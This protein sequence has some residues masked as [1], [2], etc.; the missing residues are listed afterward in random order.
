MSNQKR[1]YMIAGEA[2]GEQIGADVMRAIQ[3][4]FPD[5]EIAGIGGESMLEAGMESLFPMQDISLMGFAEIIPHLFSLLQR[6]RQ[7]VGDIMARQPDILITIDSPGFNNRVIK[8][9]K[10]RGFK[11]P[12]IHIVAP[13]VWAYKPKRAERAAKLYDHLLTILPFEAPYFEKHGLNTTF[14]GHPYAWKWLERPDGDSFKYE[15][16]IDYN[17]MLIGLMPGSRASEI[18]HHLPIFKEAIRQLIPVIDDFAVVIPTRN[19]LVKLIEQ[20]TKDWPTKLYVVV[21]DEKKFN[22]IAACRTA[23]AKSG[24]VSLEMAFAGVPAITA[25]KANPISAWLVRQMI[26]IQYVNLI[27]II[28]NRAVVPEY[29]QEDCNADLLAEAVGMVTTDEEKRAE[30]KADYNAVKKSLLL[31]KE[32]SPSEYAVDVIANYL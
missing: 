1:I 12:I 3:D 9:L 23:L 10:K 31:S 5:A 4:R 29:L 13:T 24:T 16:K 26:S 11:Q 14:I 30:M 7:T 32:K 27:N 19:H 18:H 28:A 2:S 15:E 25:Y 6:I 17:T 20:Y 21:G 22:A 8:G